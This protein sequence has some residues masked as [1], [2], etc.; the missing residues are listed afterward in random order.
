VHQQKSGQ[1]RKF[2]RSLRYSHLKPPTRL[3]LNLNLNLN[4]DVAIY[5][6]GMLLTY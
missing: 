5:K 1:R 2:D 4:E 6:T 3:S